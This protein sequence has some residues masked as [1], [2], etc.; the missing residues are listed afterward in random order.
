V[1]HKRPQKDMID[2]AKEL[3]ERK[4]GPFKPDAFKDHYGQALKALVAEKR[5]KGRITDVEEEEAPRPKGDNVIDLMDALKKS[6]TGKGKADAT[7]RKAG[8]RKKSP[9]KRAAR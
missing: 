7:P 4:A 5:K 6:I 9:R 3:I 2:L 8:S 1:P